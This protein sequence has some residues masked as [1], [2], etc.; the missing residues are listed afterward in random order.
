M[1]LLKGFKLDCSA[2]PTGHEGHDG[3]PES[4]VGSAANA[5]G[6]I[7]SFH[8]LGNPKTQCQSSCFYPFASVFGARGAGADAG[9]E[10]SPFLNPALNPNLLS[11]FG[12]QGAGAEAASADTRPPEEVYEMKLPQMNDIGVFDFERN[13]RALRCSGGSVKGAIEMLF[14]GSV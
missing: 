13:V 10:A 9:L 6:T 1:P 8:I 2:Q 7:S 5:D 12:N 3:V 14:N 11:M 4:N